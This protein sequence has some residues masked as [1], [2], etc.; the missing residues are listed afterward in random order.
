MSRIHY[1]LSQHN[2]GILEADQQDDPHMITEVIEIREAPED[3][4]AES[5]VDGI[6]NDITGKIPETRGY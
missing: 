2:L 1:I 5:S 6:K 4:F 3:A